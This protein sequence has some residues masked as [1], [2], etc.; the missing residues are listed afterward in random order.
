MYQKICGARQVWACR[1]PKMLRKCKIFLLSGALVALT[2]TGLGLFGQTSGQNQQKKH[3]RRMVSFAEGK[4]I[5]EAAWTHRSS[6]DGIPYKPDCSH[7]VHEIYS[8]VG[9]DY[10]YAP[11]TDLYYNHVA[12]FRRVFHPQPG[13]LI[14][15]LGHVGIVVSPLDHSFYSSLNSGLLTDNYLKRY[16]RKRGTPHFYRYSL[17]N[18]M[19]RIHLDLSRT[20][21]THLQS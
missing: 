11:S 9:L 12:S 1:N 19:Q 17:A 2:F 7:L 3:W 4:A 21:V 15:W 8:L 13:D 10:D 18:G 14:V 16:W 5:L 20:L 6:I